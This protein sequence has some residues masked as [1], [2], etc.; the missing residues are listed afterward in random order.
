VNKVLAIINLDTH[1][2]RGEAP[3]LMVVNNRERSRIAREY[4][5][6]FASR[7]QTSAFFAKMFDPELVQ[8]DVIEEEARA[9]IEQIEARGAQ[10]V[11][12]SSRPHTMQAETSQWLAEQG[13]LRP[14]YFKNYGTGEPG[15]DGKP[16]VSDR[17]MKTADWKERE[18]GRIITEMER[19]L[20]EKLAFVLFADDEETSRAA[21]ANLGDPRILL[22]CSLE[23]VATHDFHRYEIDQNAPPFKR[24]L[25]ELANLLE[26]REAFEQ[27]DQC[28]LTITRPEI[29][30]QEGNERLTSVMIE[31]WKA[32]ADA[33]GAALP[34]RFYRYNELYPQRNELSEIEQIIALQVCCD[35]AGRVVSL[36]MAKHGA[37]LSLL[38]E[39]EDVFDPD[40]PEAQRYADE[41]VA[42][43]FLEF[44][45]VEVARAQRG[46]QILGKSALD[47]YLAHVS[48]KNEEIKL[49][50]RGGTVG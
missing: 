39:L 40:E 4:A 18:V 49:A 3:L 5:N 12:L 9:H 10:I 27:A 43:T 6:R 41:W 34:L 37:A 38:D 8:H 23:D 1:R 31:S 7:E 22:R 14:C 17:Y 25:Q 26:M 36:K 30:G 33:P 35:Q 13:I 20:G 45:Y 2:E 50:L 15:P 48:A 46:M 42:H 11:Y 19:D 29:P 32:E 47:V 16:D 44:G 21:V 24:R 28:K